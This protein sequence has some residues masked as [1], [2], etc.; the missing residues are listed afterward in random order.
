MDDLGKIAEAAKYFDQW[1]GEKSGYEYWRA[2]GLIDLKFHRNLPEAIEAYEKAKTIWPGPVDWR[3]W[4]LLS[5]CQRENGQ[6][7]EAADTAKRSNEIERLMRADI[8]STL[9]ANLGNL[10]DPKGL[11]D[12][13]RFYEDLGM[14]R[15]AKAWQS[16][17]DSLNSKAPSEGS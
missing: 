7:T 12:V 15:E 11:E 16:V 8:Q 10:D 2:K 9:R 14:N 13:I 17:V 5:N 3:T 4:N 1:P 6:A